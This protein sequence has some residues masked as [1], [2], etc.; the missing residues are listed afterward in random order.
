MAP[1]AASC[2]L[3]LLALLSTSASVSA[4]LSHHPLPVVAIAVATFVPPSQVSITRDE[5]SRL[6]DQFQTQK[7]NEQQEQQKR[8]QQGRNGR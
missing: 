4:I 7:F 6:A 2:L 8:Q 5:L 3:A 1:R